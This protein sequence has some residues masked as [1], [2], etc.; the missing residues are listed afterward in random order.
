MPLILALASQQRALQVSGRRLTAIHPITNER[1]VVPDPATRS[2][3]FENRA[4]FGYTGLSIVERS[5]T[6]VWIAETIAQ[7]RDG[8]V[9]RAIEL[10]RLGLQRA[11]RPFMIPDPVPYQAVLVSGFRIVDGVFRAFNALIANSMN[12]RLPRRTF[13][14]E[15]LDAPRGR[16]A[17]TQAPRWIKPQAFTALNQTLERAAA[18]DE[19]FAGGADILARSIRDVAARHVEVGADLVVTSIPIPTDSYVR[20]ASEGRGPIEAGRTFEYLS[21]NRGPTR[22]DPTMVL[23]GIIYRDPIE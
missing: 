16:M 10:V 3:V 13:A 1:S 2:V 23:N 18:R 9:M 17:L 6:D 7:A 8:D 5:R 19:M 22:F 4:I 12:E 20:Q 15:M 11:F 21:P 14:I